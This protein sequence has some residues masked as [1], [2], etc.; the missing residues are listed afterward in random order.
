VIDAKQLKKIIYFLD[1]P[2]CIGG[3]NKVLLT[4]AYIMSQRGYKVVVVIPNDENGMHTPEYDKICQS[5]GLCTKTTKYSISASMEGIDIVDVWEHYEEIFQLLRKEKADLIHSTQINITVELASRELKIPHI[6]NIYQTD[7]ETFNIKWMNVYPS[8]HSAD[9]QLFSNRWGQGLGIPSRC[10]RVAYEN[11]CKKIFNKIEHKTLKILSIG[12]LTERKNQLEIIKFILLCKKNHI[13][14]S[15]TILGNSNTPYG[16]L[17]KDFVRINDLEDYVFFPGFISNIEEYFAQADLMILASKVESYPGV[18]VESMANK[19]P[20]LSTPVAGVPELLEDEYNGFLTKGFYSDD[21]YKSFMYYL[22]YKNNGEIEN[23][24]NQAYKTYLQYHSYKAVGDELEEYYNWILG[25]Y[26]NKSNHISIENLERIFKIFAKEKTLDCMSFYTKKN[27]WFLYHLSKEINQKENKKIGIWGAGNFGEIALEWIEILGY[28]N[29]FIGFIDT[30][31]E[32]EYLDYPIVRPDKRIIETCD[33]I[34]LAIG[35]ENNCIK[36]MRYL[37][38]FGKKRN[39][40]YFM[41]VNAP[42]RI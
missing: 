41:V 20:V 5:Y 1:F 32:G 34:L 38:G 2:F 26:L 15:L 25:N 35:D 23:I 7:L 30:Y 21:I 19:V 4:Q 22:I 37:E 9:S 16:K 33:I 18:I 36:I 13:Q 12:I 40:D 27:I 42:I 14:V 17:C 39:K 8:Y 10:I 11:N 29:C 28:I 6:M 24:I 3:S 31:K